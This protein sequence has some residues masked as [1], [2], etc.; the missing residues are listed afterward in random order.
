MIKLARILRDRDDLKRHYTLFV[1]LW[2]TLGIALLILKA[3]MDQSPFPSLLSTF[4]FLHCSKQYLNH[5]HRLPLFEKSK[6]NPI[7]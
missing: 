2:G 1:F 5:H 6:S 3:L 4:F 7:F